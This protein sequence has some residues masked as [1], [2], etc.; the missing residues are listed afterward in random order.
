MR[1]HALGIDTKKWAQATAKAVGLRMSGLAGL[2]AYFFLATAVHGQRG[3][4]G[5]F[6]TSAEYGLTSTTE[7]SCESCC[8]IDLAVSRCIS[9][10]R[11]HFPFEGTQT[12]AIIT[13]FNVGRRTE[14]IRMQDVES[15]DQLRDLFRRWHARQ[16]NAAELK[17]PDG[18]DCYV[19]PTNPPQGVHR[20]GRAVQSAPWRGRG[21]QLRMD[22]V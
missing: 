19:L 3:D 18:V 22:H 10:S 8:S 7:K 16:P 20:V 14:S 21:Y 6:V 9:L 4:V 5:C 15:L 17:L 2:H 12:T 13:T 1:H 11:Q